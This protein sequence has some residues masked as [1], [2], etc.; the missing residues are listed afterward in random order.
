M[1]E[2]NRILA[3]M[4]LINKGYWNAALELM[5]LSAGDILFGPDISIDYVYFPV[6]CIVS[7]SS[8]AG[9]DQFAS[10]ALIGNEGVVG[11]S[12]FLGDMS[13]TYLARVE[14]SGKAYRLDIHFAIEVAAQLSQFRILILSYMQALVQYSLQVAICESKHTTIQ[15]LICALLRCEDRLAGASSSLDLKFILHSIG[16]TVEQATQAITLL[17]NWGFIRRE[18]GS[19]VILNRACLEEKSCQCYQLVK[20]E[21]DRLLPNRA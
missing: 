17:E 15:R 4:P 19:I 7:L 8:Q 14:C 20:T 6:N 13:N 9:N 2:E 18:S 21:F 12:V 11:A 3:G 10:F 1:I 16:V 5:D